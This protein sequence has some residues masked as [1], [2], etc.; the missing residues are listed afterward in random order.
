MDEQSKYDHEET[1]SMS[2]VESCTCH[3]ERRVYGC[4]VKLGKQQQAD[5]NPPKLVKESDVR[6]EV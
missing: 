5:R 6:L 1:E 4:T 3:G 2:Y